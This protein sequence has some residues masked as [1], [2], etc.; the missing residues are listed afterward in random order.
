MRVGVVASFLLAACGSPSLSVI[1][2]HTETAR[3]APVEDSSIVEWDRTTVAP[4]SIRIAD[5]Y[6]VVRLERPARESRPPRSRRVDVSFHR[7][8][9]ANALRFLSDRAGFS[10]VIDGAMDGEVTLDL[11]RVDPYDALVAI[12]E[13]HGAEVTTRDSMVIVRARR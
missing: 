8:G 9:L 2:E 1:G 11:R 7:A 5:R 4:R 10:L 12:A 6:E 13:A 3:S